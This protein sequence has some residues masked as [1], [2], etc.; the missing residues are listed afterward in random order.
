L[1]VLPDQFATTGIEL[2]PEE[3]SKTVAFGREFLDAWPGIPFD[4]WDL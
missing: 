2:P 3:V 1:R 4:R